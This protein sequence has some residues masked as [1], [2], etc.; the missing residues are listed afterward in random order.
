MEIIS[1]LLYDMHSIDFLPHKSCTKVFS[2]YL[3]FISDS[4]M[5]LPFS[6]QQHSNIVKITFVIDIV[7]LFPPPL[8][9]FALSRVGFFFL[10][11]QFLLSLFLFFHLFYLLSISHYM[12]TLL[13]TTAVFFHKYEVSQGQ[14]NV[15]NT[16]HILLTLS[17]EIKSALPFC[18]LVE[19][20][21]HST[22]LHTLTQINPSY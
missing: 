5:L 7:K 14:K 9:A 8:S 3:H 13:S 21:M 17:P 4:L 22:H 16:P 10:S 11:F 1:L 15:F 18:S 6:Q 19:I 12:D 2:K 20:N